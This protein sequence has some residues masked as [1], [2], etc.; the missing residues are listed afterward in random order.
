MSLVR[1]LPLIALAS[2]LAAQPA[3]VESTPDSLSLNDA[4][5]HGVR[6]GWGDLRALHFGPSDVE[7]RFTFGRQSGLSLARRDGV[8]SVR[9]SGTR[10]VCRPPGGS[11][12]WLGSEGFEDCISEADREVR[13]APADSLLIARPPSQESMAGAW[14]EAVRLGLMALP[15]EQDIKAE[16]GSI[17]VSNLP[18]TIIEVR[19]SRRYR[20]TTN[21]GL[22]RL[23]IGRRM[24]EILHVIRRATDGPP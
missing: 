17:W 21:N 6:N 23:E 16:N 4:I 2:G 13:L 22:A 11:A 9:E 24:R 15:P 18:R 8:W 20:A 10:L 7:V 12:S 14:E 1:L 3:V 5:R 19:E